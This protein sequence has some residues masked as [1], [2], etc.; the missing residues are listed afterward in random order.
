V[1][2]FGSLHCLIRV[3]CCD[4]VSLSLVSFGHRYVFMGSS[5]KQ[6]G[7]RKSA[8]QSAQKNKGQKNK[9]QSGGRRQARATTDE[10]RSKRTASGRPKRTHSA[11]GAKPKTSNFD[12]GKSTS[13]PRIRRKAEPVPRADGRIRLQ[14]FLASTGL[15]SR[16]KCEEYI[17]TG[18]VSVDGKEVLDVGT[19]IDPF[20]QK[21]RVD[22]ELIRTEP[23]RYFLLNKPKGYLCT[24][25]DPRG[26]RRAVDL[27]S[28][29][30]LRL[31][32]VGRLD[33]HSEGLLLVTN[34]GE[35]ANLLAHPRYEVS[36]TYRV[37]VAGIPKKETIF[38][39]KQ[40]IHFSHGFFKVRGVRRMK[41]QGKSSFLEIELTE[42]K[43]R[44][45]RRL[46]ARVGH[47]VLNLTRISFGPLKLGRLVSG[48]SRPLRAVE[49]KAL[50]D[51]VA[52]RGESSDKPKVT[53]QGGATGKPGQ[54]KRTRSKAKPGSRT[55]TGKRP[56][57]GPK[58]ADSKAPA[59]SGREAESQRVTTQAVAGKKSS[60]DTKKSA[61]RKKSAGKKVHHK[62]PAPPK[63]KSQPRRRI[64]LE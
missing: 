58:T 24:N 46:F 60:A 38:Q 7:K 20:T 62:K 9:G 39:L 51:Y 42:G 54:D 30:N 53:R 6:S 40:G 25:M 35:M 17:L 29:K 15:D 23:K 26:R 22:G 57:P 4:P 3:A 16:R 5:R 50:R 11:T 56:G 59:R 44:E 49:L 43:N 2:F 64:T 52:S 27:V 37:Q 63:K 32:T 55:S 1:A 41:T 34:D 12:T 13:K 14:R 10:G 31:F 28:A 18:R 45:I 48:K 36:R 47:K 21:I 19:V 33:E 8:G 61:T